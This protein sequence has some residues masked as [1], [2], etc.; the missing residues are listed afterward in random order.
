M[1]P[2]GVRL[3]IAIR[4]SNLLE[5]EKKLMALTDLEKM[6]TDDDY[7]KRTKVDKCLIEEDLGRTVFHHLWSASDLGVTFWYKIDEIIGRI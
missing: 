1:K 7:S 3:A 5:D 4:D 2:L 6:Y